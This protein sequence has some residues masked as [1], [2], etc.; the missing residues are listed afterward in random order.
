MLFKMGGSHSR[1]LFKSHIEGRLAVISNRVKDFQNCFMPVI[2][3]FQEMQRFLNAVAVDEIVEVLVK[4]IVD[5]L[6]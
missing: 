5:D 6:R 4:R 2:P 3:V 1:V